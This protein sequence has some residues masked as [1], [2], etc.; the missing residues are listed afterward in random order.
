MLLLNGSQ[1]GLTYTAH[2]FIYLLAGVRH[3][4]P[5]AAALMKNNFVSRLGTACRAP[6]GGK[7]R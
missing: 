1:W 5:S 2:F 7:A 4:A 3:A 6:T